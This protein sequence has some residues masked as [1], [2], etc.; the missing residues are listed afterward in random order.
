MLRNRHADNVN[1]DSHFLQALNAVI[2]SDPEQLIGEKKDVFALLSTLPGFH[3]SYK[4]ATGTLDRVVRA[5]GFNYLRLYRM[6]GERD[7]ERRVAFARVL[8]AIPLRC[9]VSVDE[10]QKD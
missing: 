9:I 2:L 7:Q 5:T 10:T 3:D 1:Y 6:C 4:T 8:T